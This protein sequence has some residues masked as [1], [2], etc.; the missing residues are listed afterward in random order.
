[1][2]IPI[3]FSEFPDDVHDFLFQIFSPHHMNITRWPPNYLL[4]KHCQ[5][6]FAV[7][8]LTL[9]KLL[10]QF[11]KTL[12]LDEYHSKGFDTPTYVTLPM[13]RVQS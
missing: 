12:A 9:T 1:M 10:N 3:S 13:S 11:E 2:N 5:S 6:G 4:P 7:S 8:T